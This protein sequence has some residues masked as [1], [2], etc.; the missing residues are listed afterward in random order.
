MMLARNGFLLHVQDLVND[1][2]TSLLVLLADDGLRAG[3][4]KALLNLFQERFGMKSR[5][6]EGALNT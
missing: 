1:F 5:A 4:V 2:K 6:T 3:C